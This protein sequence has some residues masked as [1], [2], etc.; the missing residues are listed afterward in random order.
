MNDHGIL[1]TP[2]IQ[3]PRSDKCRRLVMAAGCFCMASAS[4]LAN[5]LVQFH[6]NDWLTYGSFAYTATFLANELI[7]RALGAEAARRVVY[8]GCVVAVPVAWWT[9][10]PRIAIAF[11]VAFLISQLLD[12]VVFSKLRRRAWWVAP[13]AASILATGIDTVI[14]FTLAFAG[15]GHS[16]WRLMLQSIS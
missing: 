11:A 14:F 6:V 8:V 7:N 1:P 16:V 9:A 12:I 2:W 3:G 4:A 5:W 15:S 13:G 10:P